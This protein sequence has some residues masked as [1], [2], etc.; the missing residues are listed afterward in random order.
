M[1]WQV[2]NPAGFFEIL[3]DKKKW[4]RLFLSRRVFFCP[5][6]QGA[7]IA[8][9]RAVLHEKGRLSGQSQTGET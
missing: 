7:C 3:K 1:V 5:A 9:M 8:A 4:R 6:L 2:L